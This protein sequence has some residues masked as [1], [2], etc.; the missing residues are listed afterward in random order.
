MALAD[1]V[2]GIL[3]RGVADG[4]VVGAVAKIV[5][6]DGEICSAAAGTRGADS[7]VAM[8]ND[9]V[10][11]IASMTKALTGTAAMQLV[12]QG[13]LSLDGPAGETLPLLDELD[14]LTGFDDSGAPV[15]RARNGDITLRQLLTH[16]AGM[17][18]DIW[19]AELGQYQEATGTPGITECQKSTLSIPLLFDPGE[20]WMY[21]TG[22]DYA[23][24]MV[25]TVSG[26]SLGEY[27]AQNVSGP[28]GMSDTA[29]RI[30]DDMRSRISAMHARME[31]GSLVEM[32]FEIPQDPEME[33][34]GGGL[35]S[36]IDDYCRFLSMMLNGGS[37]DGRQI[38]SADTHQ[39]MVSNAMGDLRVTMLHSAIPPYSNDAEFFP[40]LE[41]SWGL[42]FQIN[43]EPAPTGR[44]AG[45]LMWAGLAN[46][47]F[48]IDLPNQ[49]AGCYISQV[50]PFADARSYQLY[51][52]IETA[53]YDSL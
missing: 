18:Y 8:T 2:Q 24:Q 53:T 27:F 32:P 25:E 7:D 49:V 6:P 47:F 29:F 26:M 19:S 22:I 46:S 12:E 40:G 30:S 35:Y 14:V 23:G 10:C 45:G 31:D 36:T 39:Q 52:D 38:V 16:T 48:W 20:R 15:T 21:G 41:K 17:G 33:M 11:W 3:D 1:T 28:L 42:T 5:G 50:V 13:K 4:D 43:E 9:T 37:V 51:E 34:G 44:P